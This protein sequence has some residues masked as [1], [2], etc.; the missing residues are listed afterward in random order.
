MRA[1]QHEPWPIL[2]PLLAV[3]RRRLV[4]T[5]KAAN[6]PWIDDPSNDDRRFERVRLRA[7][8]PALAE[9]G[10]AD[11]SV[12]LSAR[13]LARADAAIEEMTAQA[14]GRLV[15]TDPLG[16]LN[17]PLDGL[18]GL[19]QELRVRLLQRVIAR[20]GGHGA[21]AELAA[22][23]T[24]ESW[25]AG[26]AA[27]VRTIQGARVERRGQAMVF[28]REP[29]RMP[30]EPQPVDPARPILFDQRFVMDVDGRSFTGSL[31]VRPVFSL[32]PPASRPKT[33]RAT[34]WATL[35]CLARHDGVPVWLPDPAAATPGVRLLALPPGASPGGVAPFP[36]G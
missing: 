34:V 28:C 33:V 14:L 32:R 11:A 6:H 7:L 29:G 25:I 31:T 19:P 2:R 35:P 27:G 5:L 18:D 23:E 1:Q 8:K 15:V 10:L 17:L 21:C 16:V 3:P 26:G 24:I 22:A 36:G 12:A 4:A 13:R 20:A 9:L 30:V